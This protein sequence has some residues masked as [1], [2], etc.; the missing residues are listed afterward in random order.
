LSRTA[1]KLCVRIFYAGVYNRNLTAVYVQAQNF[2]RFKGV[3]QLKRR[4][5]SCF[6]I[7]KK[8]FKMYTY[9]FRGHLITQPLVLNYRKSVPVIHRHRTS[10]SEMR[11]QETVQLR[12][13]CDKRL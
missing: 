2:V 10:C 1:L 7:L 11:T 5:K 12:T 3:Q 6:W 8:M 4:K 13:A 9:R